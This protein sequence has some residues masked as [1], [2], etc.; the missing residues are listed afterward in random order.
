M[1]LSEVSNCI[2]KN[3]HELS[4]YDAKLDRLTDYITRRLH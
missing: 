1:A 2:E 4:N 3:T